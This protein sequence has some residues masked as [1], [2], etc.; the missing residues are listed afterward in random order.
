MLLSPHTRHPVYAGKPENIVGVLHVKALLRA[1]EENS[2]RDISGL[3]IT[4]IAT[5]PYFVPETTQL[6]AQLQAFRKRRE[7]FAIVI[8]EY[9][10][11]RGI[12]TLE[13]ILEEI[14]GEIDDEHDEGLPEGKTTGRWKLH[15][16]WLCYL[17]GFEPYS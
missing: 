17:A 15:C 12:V 7:H 16:W 6:F 11:L 13:D 14:V 9:G 10:D 1:I 5:E 8:D 4:D 3:S 2:A